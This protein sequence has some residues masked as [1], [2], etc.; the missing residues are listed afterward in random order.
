MTEQNTTQDDEMNAGLTIAERD[1]LQ[2][3][4][5][6]MADTMP[7]R[8]VWNR[9]EEQA[10][11]EGLLKK[12]SMPE[13]A[14]WFSGIGLAAA[15]VL[16][17]IILPNTG[18]RMAP[19]TTAQTNEFPTEPV[20][21][22]SA[23]AVNNRQF[24]S[25]NALMVQSQLLERD[26]RALPEQ[27]LVRRAGTIATIAGLQDRIAAIDYQLNHPESRM[28]P[29]QQEVFWRERVRLMDSLVQL[30]YAQAQRTSF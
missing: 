3:K 30:R 19:P 26:L 21:S 9:I 20:Y 25:I 13:A 1:V 16:A 6:E 4:L 17:V 22:A 7:P 18:N 12:S 29:Q 24:Q 8:A 15:V 14:K 28:T 5:R 10:R 27:P 11:A 23:D 2:M